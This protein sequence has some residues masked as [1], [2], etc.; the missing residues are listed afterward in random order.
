MKLAYLEDTKD[1]NLNIE[2]N[3]NPHK[4]SDGDEALMTVKWYNLIQAFNF[5]FL[6]V[7]LSTVMF[8]ME[9]IGNYLNL[10]GVAWGHYRM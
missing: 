5:F 7:V 2:S 3:N 8:L 4:W 9:L 10:Y 1:I 6:C